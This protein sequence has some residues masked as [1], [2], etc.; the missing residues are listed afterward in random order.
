MRDGDLGQRHC[1]IES[2][3]NLYIHFIHV[4]NHNDSL[5]VGIALLFRNKAH[6]FRSNITFLWRH[7][8]FFA[9]LAILRKN[10]CAYTYYKAVSSIH[11]P[12][13]RLR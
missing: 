5:C 10:M 1:S 11:K 12:I 7:E 13:I 2:S 3:L 4:N 9:F 6:G 8:Q